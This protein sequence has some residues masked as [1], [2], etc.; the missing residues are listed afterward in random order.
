[1][2]KIIGL[3]LCFCVCLVFICSC[4]KDGKVL[5]SNI[6][7]TDTMVGC[8][9][10]VLYRDKQNAFLK[11][12]EFMGVPEYIIVT[13]ENIAGKYPDFRDDI[14]DCQTI[15]IEKNYDKLYDRYVTKNF[16]DIYQPI[17]EG[18]NGR[19]ARI[20][21]ELDGAQLRSVSKQKLTGVIY[22]ENNLTSAYEFTPGTYRL[23][24]E[25]SD[26]SLDRT[27]FRIY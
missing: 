5:E 4:A 27:E 16:G 26:G 18:E 20:P 17:T 1:M 15:F 11:R 6:S 12:T 24:L 23:V 19:W 8:T 7:S 14:A 10:K 9:T 13:I 22:L 3:L 25:Y 21:F 2:K